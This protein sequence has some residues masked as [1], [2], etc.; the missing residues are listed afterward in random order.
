MLKNLSIK[1]FAILDDINLE[2]APG[3]NVF[4]GE[5]GA[6]K[7]IIIEALGFVLGARGGSS[8][9]KEGA[10][11]MSVSASFDSSFIPKNVAAKYN[12]CGPVINIKR[13]LDIKGKGKGWINNTVVPAGALAELGEFLVDFH[14]QHDHHTLLKTSTHL[15]LLDKF[16]KNHKHLEGIALYYNKMRDIMSKIE[17]LHM[18]KTQKEKLLDLY[19]FQYKEIMDV[20]LKPGED[21]EIDNALP[22]LKH[23][24]KLK[25]LAKDAYNLL[26]EG[27]TAGIDLISKAE[28][29]ISEM[30][31]LD[32][33]L[34]PVL[35]EVTSSL[36]NLEDAAQTL[37]T[38]NENIEADPSILDAMLSRQQKINNLKLKYGPEIQDILN[39][40]EIFLKQI[41]S[42]SYSEEKEQELQQELA[43]VKEKLMKGC[44]V[45]HESRVT[46][47]S[48]LDSLITLEIS[49]L[50]F[51]DVKFKTD[52]IF[53]EESLGPKGANIVE[54]LFSPNPGQ[55]L[56][57]LKNIASGGEMSRV[58]L[59]LKTVLAGNTPV[60]VFD[61]IDAGIGGHT[62]LLVGQKLKKVSLGKQTLCVTHLAQV[63]VY[64]DKHFNVSKTSDKKNTR[65]TVTQ[66]DS[67]AKTLEIARML[68]ST[69]GKDSAGFKHAQELIK[70][71]RETA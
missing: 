29:N 35:E 60:M 51:N 24:G 27:E 45:L 39:N 47:A 36:R 53:E 34:A 64:G 26:Y 5:T 41:E 23:S 10:G 25:E 31:E 70:H 7:S 14:G 12:I 63:A 30:S 18:S 40:A 33:A 9:I 50:G 57:P 3:L 56:R 15:D 38:Y 48:K 32:E 52:I 8:L 67:D 19:R 11:K 2:P 66:L 61:E 62:G 22:K 43:E 65:V 21:I 46:A 4:S 20:N 6:G 28:K 44:M 49:K 68:G 71:S 1:N 55:S 37:Y 17:A 42:L 58:M 59:G 54:F 16:A 69:H 13:E